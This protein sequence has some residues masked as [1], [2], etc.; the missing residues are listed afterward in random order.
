MKTLQYIALILTALALVPGGAHLMSMLAKIDM[1]EQPYFVAQQIY[2]GWAW[3]GVAIIAALLAN[4]GSALLARQFP[5][6]F[7]LSLAAALLVAASLAVFF[8]WTYPANQ[9][10]GNWTSIPDGWE[11]LR[12]QWEY[13]H[14]AG[15]I[16]M[17]A[18]LLC[19]AGAAISSAV[20]SSLSEHP[21]RGDSIR[22]TTRGA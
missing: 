12:T 4:L 5:R 13:S 2:R 11:Q 22:G 3:A 9:A 16:L 17:F 1:P 14:A 20:P 10:T 8:A 19:S 6:Q 21:S 15:A 18:A 7:C